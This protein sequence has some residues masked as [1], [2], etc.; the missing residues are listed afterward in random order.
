MKKNEAIKHYGGVVQLAAALGIKPQSVSQ[1]GDT[2]P[3]GRA[4]QIELLT[5]GQLKADQPHA[6]Q[7]RA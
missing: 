6:A 3:Q 7:G 2:I 1:W 4:Y 5:G